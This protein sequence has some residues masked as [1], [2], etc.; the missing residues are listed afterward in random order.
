[1]GL[2]ALRYPHPSSFCAKALVTGEHHMLMDLNFYE[3]AQVTNA[4]A[5]HD[6]LDQREKKRQKKTLRQAP[7]VGRST[8][9][10]IAHLI[11]KR[12]LFLGLLSKP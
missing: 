3:E 1:M 8:T 2:S 10:S 6:Q 4:K 7:S 9:S 12:S 11:S 5:R